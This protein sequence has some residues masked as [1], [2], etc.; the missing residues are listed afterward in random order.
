MDGREGAGEEEEKWPD[1]RACGDKRRSSPD[2]KGGGGGRPVAITCHGQVLVSTEKIYN[3]PVPSSAVWETGGLI[4]CVWPDPLIKDLC[5]KGQCVPFRM[6][7]STINWAVA[8]LII[9]AKFCGGDWIV[10]G[11]RESTAPPPC[12]GSCVGSKGST[13]SY[14]SLSPCVRSSEA[15]RQQWTYN[16]QS[17][18]VVYTPS[19]QQILLCVQADKTNVYLAVCNQNA[20]QSWVKEEDGSIR[21]SM[22]SEPLYLQAPAQPSLPL[23]LGD[24]NNATRFTWLTPSVVNQY[25]PPLPVTNSSNLIR[26]GGFDDIVLVNG[27]STINSGLYLYSVCSWTLGSSGAVNAL[28]GREGGIQGNFSLDLFDYGSIEQRVPTYD[29]STYLLFFQISGNGSCSS[30]LKEVRV[31]V[32]PSSLVSKVFSWNATEDPPWKIE[33]GRFV[34]NSTSVL[35][36]FTSYNGASSCGPVIDSVQMYL[37]NDSMSTNTIES[38][39]KPK[40]LRYRR[41]GRRLESENGVDD[42]VQRYTFDQ[43]QSFTNNFSDL[44]GEG[45]FGRV[46]RGKRNDGLAIAVKRLT[47]PNEGHESSFQEEVR[48]L[49]RVH[50]RYVVE[51]LRFCSEGAERI[52]VFEYMPNGSLRDYLHQRSSSDGRSLTWDYRMRIAFQIAYGLEYLHHGANPPVVHRDVKTANVLLDENLGAKIADFGLSRVGRRDRDGVATTWTRPKGTPGYMDPQYFRTYRLSQKSDVFSYGVLL[53]ELITGRKAIQNEENLV[54]WADPF[55]NGDQDRI[56]MLDQNLRNSFD[57]SHLESVSNICRSCLMAD[58][59]DR[60]SM[61]EVVK[62]INEKLIKMSEKGE[63]DNRPASPKVSDESTGTTDVSAGSLITT[64]RLL[65]EISVNAASGEY[66]CLRQAG[67]IHAS[68]RSSLTRRREDLMGASIP[69]R[70][71]TQSRQI[72]DRF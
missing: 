68:I 63:D 11:V 7:F 33:Y 45:G 38:N 70:R 17:G 18:T 71:E 25:V 16:N 35:V 29:G 50:H 58:G 24:R 4:L 64:M 72:V 19:N 21:S 66:H 9:C 42:T 39:S 10:E 28:N 32:S 48:M 37:S 54:R 5:R 13:G 40:A 53:L 41:V 52:M 36:Q 60:P 22:P 61:L 34:V 1:G 46:Y 67:G 2:G 49:S 26:N 51:F 3:G 59:K 6:G 14:I 55:L 65:V 69:P 47:K 15:S 44:I 23:I 27:D 57:P 20:S 31:D 56:Q 62:I 30:P 12:G 43:I 8:S